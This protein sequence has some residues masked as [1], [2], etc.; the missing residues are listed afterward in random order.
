MGPRR[1]TGSYRRRMSPL[2]NW[3]AAEV[4][5]TGSD[6]TMEVRH[7][8]ASHRAA[9]HLEREPE[10]WLEA[11]GHYHIVT[12]VRAAREIQ[13]V[14]FTGSLELSGEA[15]LEIPAGDL[16]AIIDKI[17]AQAEERGRA[18][19]DADRRR[20]AAWQAALQDKQAGAG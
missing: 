12:T 4:S 17:A 9:R 15:L 3:P 7:R 6:H 20:M 5:W 1:G 10:V 2:I 13:N 14:V 18:E 19:D 11:N 8:V 16:R